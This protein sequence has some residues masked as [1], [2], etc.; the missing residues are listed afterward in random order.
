M[1]KLRDEIASLQRQ[2]QQKD[3]E[4][5]RMKNHE[6]SKPATSEKNRSNASGAV[7]KDQS[8]SNAAESRITEKKKESSSPK[9]P[10]EKSLSM[11]ASHVS[12]VQATPS[13]QS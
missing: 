6:P 10:E 13:K 1:K 8:F 4:L 11:E 2:L 5:K 12:E 3:Y 7:K 9:K